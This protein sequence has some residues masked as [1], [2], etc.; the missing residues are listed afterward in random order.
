MSRVRRLS[1]GLYWA[2]VDGEIFQV[3]QVRRDTGCGCVNLWE[4]R[5]VFGAAPSQWLGDFPT[6]TEG[7]R[8][9]GA[10]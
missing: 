4:L 1:P 10:R 2:W 3:A 6:L 7:L 5:Q 8:Q 9:V